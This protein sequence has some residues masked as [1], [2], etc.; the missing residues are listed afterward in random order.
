M[1]P[2]FERLVGRAVMD[3]DFREKL[4]AD[5]EGS[6]K[7]SGLGLT[8]DEVEQVKQSVEQLKKELT[9]DQIARPFAG[10]RGSSWK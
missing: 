3:A 10:G 7:A 8:P 6:I 5:P 9:P 2:D 4:M 1:S